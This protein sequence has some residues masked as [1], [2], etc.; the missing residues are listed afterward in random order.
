MRSKASLA[1]VLV[2][3]SFVVTAV[4]GVYAQTQSSAT[5]KTTKQ[6]ATKKVSQTKPV[7][8]KTASAPVTPPQVFVTV[9]SGDSLSSIAS[10]QQTTYVRL[11][12]ANTDITNPDVIYPGQKLRIPTA[13]EQLAD[14]PLPTAVVAAPVAAEPVSAPTP[15][16][17]P[18]VSTPVVQATPV[19]SSVSASDGS[20]WDRIAACESGGN[21]AIN[22]GNGFYGGLQFTISSW[23]AVGGS[24]LPSQA[25]REEQIARAQMLQARQGWGAWPVCSTKAGA[26]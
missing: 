1:T 17:A 22:T 14:R 2:A 24:G 12:D 26:Y 8:V 7:E 20:V 18:V 4:S 25:S 3:A 13:D 23:H 5:T 19:V 16:A 10:A 6:P 21:W 9:A 15:V 11:F